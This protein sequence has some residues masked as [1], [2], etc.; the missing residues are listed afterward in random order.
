M[1]DIYEKLETYDIVLTPHLDTDYPADGLLPDDS[2][3]LR[4]GQFNLGFI[5]I[6]SSENAKSFLNWWKPKL[7]EHCVVDV[8]N[9]YFVDQK[10]I[11]FVPVLFEN[12]HVEKQTGYNVAYWNLH[13]RRVHK[14]NGAWHCNESPLYFFHF[15]GYDPGTDAIFEPYSRERCPTPAFR[16]RPTR[17]TCSLNTESCCLRMA[18]MKQAPGPTPL[19]FSRLA[20]QFRT[21]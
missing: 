7:Y 15:S 17:A 6:N 14:Q 13:S 10:F 20:S 9:G 8:M 11:D 12:F 4:A 18:G 5:G 1:D 16:D 19:D 21:N 2:H 3:I